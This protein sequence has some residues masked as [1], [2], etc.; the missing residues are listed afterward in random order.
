MNM[1]VYIIANNIKPKKVNTHVSVS[2]YETQFKNKRRKKNVHVAKH[3][4]DIKVNTHAA[5]CNKVI[6]AIMRNHS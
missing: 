5:I 3:C 2:E 6:K 4:E 1:S